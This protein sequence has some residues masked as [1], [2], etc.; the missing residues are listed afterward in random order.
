M[1]KLACFCCVV[2]LCG[3]RPTVAG[4]LS[5]T[6]FGP[7]GVT[8]PKAPVQV[9]GAD[10][11][12]TG[13]T[14][15][16][17][18][19]RYAVGNLPPGRYEV[20]VVTACCTFMP[21][22]KA[23]IQIG[24]YQ[25]VKLDIHLAEGVALGTL[26]DDPAANAELLRRRAKVPDAPAPHTVDGKP[27][28]SGLWLVNDDPYPQQ[29]EALPWAD[30]LAKERLRNSGKDAPHTH[31]LPEGLPVPSATS[32]FMGKFVQTPSSLLVLFEDVPGF[33]QIFLDGRRHPADGNSTWLGHSIGRWDGDT[34]VVDTIGFND[35]G[36]VELYPR[37]E[38]LHM[39]ER[40]HRPDF[41]HLEVDV[42]FEDP[43]TFAKTWSRHM[44]WDLLPHEELL[45]YV[46]EAPS[47]SDDE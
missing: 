24:R 42:T 9:R 45:E 37:T 16:S 3:A 21:F 22:S 2:A 46:C 38:R 29:P 28:L 20:S 11:E 31:C 30:A 40:Y 6:V 44:T 26:G 19:G 47:S 17:E 14:F 36:W 32:P 10:P 1:H 18:A 5:G 4:S 34:L 33:R 7:G 39:I 12:Y 43:G 41:G 25:D 13:R 23:D 35:R 27:D 8:V 15:S